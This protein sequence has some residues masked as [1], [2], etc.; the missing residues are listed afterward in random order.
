[1]QIY[2]LLLIRKDFH[3][4]IPDIIVHLFQST[5]KTIKEPKNKPQ[6]IWKQK[7]CSYICEQN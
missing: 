2:I 4:I 5:D 7:H 1:M 3:T 6:F